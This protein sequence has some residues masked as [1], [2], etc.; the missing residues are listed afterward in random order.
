MFLSCIYI[1]G[2]GICGSELNLTKLQQTDPARYQRVM[3]L[4]NRI[5][6]FLND[7]VLRSGSQQSTIYVPVVVHIVY[8]NSAQN[9]S[10][11][12]VHSQIDVLNED[13]RRRN[14]DAAKTP[15]AFAHL[16]GDANIEF[17]LAKV[18]PLGKETNGI[19][20]TSTTQN[21]FYQND[22]GVKYWVVPWNTDRYLNIW[23]CDIWFIDDGDNQYNNQ[24]ENF[25]LSIGL[26]LL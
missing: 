20:R 6:E 26:Y 14:A 1:Y 13:F 10:D 8:K 16:A 7:P 19:T 25:I 4:E 24:C 11:A 18:D 5:Q 21:K 17:V 23:V 12:Q 22:D 9:I 3:D 15:P 2:Q